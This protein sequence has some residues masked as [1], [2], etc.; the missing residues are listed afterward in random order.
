MSQVK[1]LEIEDAPSEGSGKRVPFEH[2]HT[3]IKYE[4]ALFQVEGKY[5]AITDRCAICGASLG[6]GPN[7]QGMFAS[8]SGQECLWNIK[9]G[10]CKFDRT[11][12]MPTYKVAARED[13]LY[14]DI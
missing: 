13:G 2:P 4:L 5:Y 10:V 14:I 1:I 9:R 3:T 8:C 6:R 11:S 12:V 7:L